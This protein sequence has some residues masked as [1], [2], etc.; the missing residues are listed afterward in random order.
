MIMSDRTQLN[1]WIEGFLIIAVRKIRK[2]EFI[3][4]LHYISENRYDE[5]LE[6]YISMLGDGIY[7]KELNIHKAERIRKLAPHYIKYKVFY[8]LT[9][10]NIMQMLSEHQRISDDYRPFDYVLTSYCENIVVEYERLCSEF[11]KYRPNKISIDGYCRLKHLNSILDI[12][13]QAG[14]ELVNLI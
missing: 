3:E 9:D 2:I 1:P 11:R 6:F 4:L 7:D 14:K 10:E 5:D 12:H 13:K 8:T